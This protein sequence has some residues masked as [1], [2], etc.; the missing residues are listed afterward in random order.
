MIGLPCTRAAHVSDR[1]V[2][3]E[4]AF[5]C[6]CMAA[7]MGLHV[8]E[9]GLPVIPMMDESDLRVAARNEVIN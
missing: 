1:L 5:T 3:P 9:A 2:L 7:S 4:R 6:K 8:A